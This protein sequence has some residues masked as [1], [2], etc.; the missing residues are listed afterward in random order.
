MGATTSDRQNGG[1]GELLGCGGPAVERA[2]PSDQKPAGMCDVEVMHAANWFGEMLFEP[3]EQ[4]AIFVERLQELLNTRFQGHWYPEEPHRGCAF[5]ALLSTV[6]CLD[7]L[8]LRA[9]ESTGQRGLQ[10]SFIKHFGDAGEV[11]CWINP[12]EVKVLRGRSQLIVFSDGT[13]SDNPYS[14]LRI[15]IEPTRLAVQVDPSN[16]MP[17][18]P[19]SSLGGHSGAMGDAFAPFRPHGSGS[20]CSSQGCS[21][22]G[23]SP[24][25]SPMQSWRGGPSVPPAMAPLPPHMGASGN[26]SYG[27]FGAMSQGFGAQ[28]MGLDGLGGGMGTMHFS[29]AN[30]LSQ[31]Q[32]SQQSSVPHSSPMRGYPS[33]SYGGQ[34]PQGQGVF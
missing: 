20:H 18:S 5:R 31:Q 19:V 27:S 2:R 34:N 17:N 7:P 14:K 28:D 3:N 15:N 6:N 10:E 25:E 33:Y 26:G 8:L 12:S 24:K 22:H 29:G 32:S 16:N 23:E 13:G 11:T 21:S 30:G 4:R 9:A 1:Y